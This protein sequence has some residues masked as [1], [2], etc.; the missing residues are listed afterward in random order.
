MDQKRYIADDEGTDY[1]GDI[2]E[3]LLGGEGSTSRQTTSRA[4]KLLYDQSISEGEG[5]GSQGN[6]RRSETSEV[7]REKGGGGS[8]LCVTVRRSRVCA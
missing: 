5:G 2:L 4:T 8:R 3:A 1:A 6:S 7:M